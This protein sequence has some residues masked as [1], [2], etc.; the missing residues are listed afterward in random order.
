MKRLSLDKLIPGMI[1]AEDV[2]DYSSQLILHKG[3]VLTQKSISKLQF[4]AIA[5]IRVEDEMADTSVAADPAAEAK[6]RT[7]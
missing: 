3:Q 1:T 7:R 5:F 2:Y 6:R 4:Y